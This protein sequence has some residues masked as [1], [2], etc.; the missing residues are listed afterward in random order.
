MLL[1]QIEDVNNIV[2]MREIVTLAYKKIFAPSGDTEY[3]S[4]KI[5]KEDYLKHI[6]SLGKVKK[7][8][9]PWE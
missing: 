5:S 2:T 6:P 9:N 1:S 7:N 4:K 3:I 8:K